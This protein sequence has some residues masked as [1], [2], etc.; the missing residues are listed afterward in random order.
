MNVRS[1]EEQQ[2]AVHRR[3]LQ[4][5]EQGVEQ[6]H[7]DGVYRQQQRDGNTET[8]RRKCVDQ[9]I[10][11]S[12][13]RHEVDVDRHHRGEVQRLVQRDEETGDVVA[14]KVAVR[15]GDDCSRN[16]VSRSGCERKSRDRSFQGPPLSTIVSPICST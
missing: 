5:L 2:H 8:H 13:E 6:Q 9:V 10:H 12:M 11:E 16:R 15:P 3:V 1:I 4:P 14:E 7:R